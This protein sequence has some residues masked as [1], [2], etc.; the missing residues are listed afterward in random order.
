MV[1]GVVFGILTIYWVK[2]VNH[3]NSLTINV[4]ISTAYLCYFAAEYVDWGVPSNGLVAVLTLGIFMS[5]FT[6]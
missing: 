1:I 3:D 5:A 2:L 4:T 6:R